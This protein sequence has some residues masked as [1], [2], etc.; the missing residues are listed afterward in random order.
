MDNCFV[1]LTT[2]A[3][4]GDETTVTPEMFLWA[5]VIGMLTPCKR[6]L[7][8]SKARPQSH[9]G[10]FSL[11][12]TDRTP[13]DSKGHMQGRAEENGISGRRK[14]RCNSYNPEDWLYIQV[15]GLGN[16]HGYP[17]ERGGI[18][19]LYPMG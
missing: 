9:F 6:R 13:H 12:I 1:G 17:R 19:S 3:N 14:P 5:E 15:R 16:E 11:A 4:Q 8:S 18:T 2:G 7:P 10:R